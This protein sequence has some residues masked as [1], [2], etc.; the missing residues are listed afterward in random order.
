[1]QADILQSTIQEVDKV[2][3]KYKYD[4]D[5]INKIITLKKKKHKQTQY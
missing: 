2:I 1:M 4:I 5:Q 3:Q